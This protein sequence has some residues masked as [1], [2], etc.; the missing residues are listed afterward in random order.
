MITIGLTTWTDHP[1]LIKEPRDVLLDEY[2]A[3]FPTV[4]V[5]SAFYGIPK[6]RPFISGRP[7][8][9]HNFNLLSKLTVK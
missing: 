1:A 9:Q 7:W 4:E 5:D 3:R 8:C 6:A 2:A